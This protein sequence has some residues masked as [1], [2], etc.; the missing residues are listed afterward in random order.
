MRLADMSTYPATQG[1]PFVILA[2]RP[3]RD[4][5]G[6]VERQS[7]LI[8]RIPLR[9][10]E[11]YR[12]HFDMSKCI[13]CKCCEVACAE[14]NNNPADV[15]WR[16]VGEMEGG[17]YPHTQR[18]YLSMGCNHCLEPSCLTGCPT[19]AYRKDPATGIVLHDANQC[20][21][22]EYC[23]WNCPYNVP[24]FNQERGV[25]GKCD[26]CH[27]RLADGQKPACVNACPSEAIQIEIVDI[28][29]WKREYRDAA[30]A[31][32][33]PSAEDTIS[34]TRVTL[35]PSLPLDARKADYYRARPEKPHYSLVAMTVF[36][37]LSVGGFIAAWLL[38][39]FAESRSPDL[40][41]TAALIV[42]L[43]S[44]GISPLHLGRPVFAFR[45][46]RNWRRSW[47]SREII[48]LSGFG[49]F[50]AA[51]AVLLWLNIAAVPVVGAVA[52]IFGLCGIAATSWLYL[53]PGRPAW[54]TPH[55]VVE[56]AL[57]A[58][59]LGPLFV[60]ALG[61]TSSVL[62]LF[63]AGA[64]IG[65]LLNQVSKF[66]ALARSDEFEK[67]ASA[68]LLSR[69]LARPFIV[70]LLLLAT[71]GVALPLMGWMI[72]GFVLA[73]AGELTGRYLFFVSVVPKNMALTF[74]ERAEAA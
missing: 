6:R 14:Q 58:A 11:Q 53:V 22:C 28:E 30:N 35:P 32:G 42:G 56:F 61:V 4:L 66:V 26:M 2:P 38:S 7:S 37:Q 40:A 45:A 24:V 47:L 39:L 65:Q 10:G 55:T 25:V 69:D 60:A 20:I 18:L 13:G 73:L 31:P 1:N 70:R 12:F 27:G 71:G 43:L 49:V 36:T 34:T 72:A 59:L 57:T 29:Q 48:S 33:L 64:A 3:V 62:S 17:V 54:R 67:Q 5:G 41:G 16:R 8:P 21:G 23:I 68:R 74:F 44:F 52:T 46:V 63:A 50:A 15:S 9:D 19:E 51:Y